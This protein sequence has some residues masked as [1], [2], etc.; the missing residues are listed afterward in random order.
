MV[1]PFKKWWF[2][3]QC[4][5][6]SGRQSSQPLGMYLEDQLYMK[7]WKS[8]SRRNNDDGESIKNIGWRNKE[9][10]IDCG[11]GVQFGLGSIQN[12]ADLAQSMVG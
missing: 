8:T 10:I 9:D 7:N 12:L 1:F 2:S 11:V 3:A 4:E 6:S 5:S